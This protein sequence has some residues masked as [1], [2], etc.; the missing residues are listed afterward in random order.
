MVVRPIDGAP[1]PSRS[2]RAHRRKAAVLMGC[3]RSGVD[4]LSPAMPLRLGG[5]RTMAPPVLH[6]HRDKPITMMAAGARAI[7][8]ASAAPLC[9]VDVV[10]AAGVV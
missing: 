10:M 4:T 5:A 9:A 1:T 3:A 8:V 7:A 2:A 6:T